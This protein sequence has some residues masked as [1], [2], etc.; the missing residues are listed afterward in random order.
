MYQLEKPR[1][2]ATLK[3]ETFS[4]KITTT[5]VQN[6]A[7]EINRIHTPSTMSIEWGDSSASDDEL[8]LEA[9]VANQ[10]SIKRGTDG[11]INGILEV[12]FGA[13][14]NFDSLNSAEWF[15][16]ENGDIFGENS[17]L[18]DGKDSYNR[19]AVTALWNQQAYL[20]LSEDEASAASSSDGVEASPTHSPLH[21]RLFEHTPLNFSDSGSSNDTEVRQPD[22]SSFHSNGFAHTPL[23]FSDSSS[24]MAS[25]KEV[26]VRR[27][28]VS[29]AWSKS[30]RFAA[31]VATPV[32]IALMDTFDIMPIPATSNDTIIEEPMDHSQNLDEID[33]SLDYDSTMFG[34]TPEL[35]DELSTESDHELPTESFE[36][37]PIIQTQQ[38]SADNTDQFGMGDVIDLDAKIGDSRNEIEAG[39]EEADSEEAKIKRG[40]LYA[41]GGMGFMAFMMWGLGKLQGAFHRGQGD[42]PIAAGDLAQTAGD[43]TGH[44]SRDAATLV[45]TEPT[46]ATGTTFQAGMYNAAGN[47]AQ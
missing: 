25:S 9:I 2:Y 15:T 24:S 11:E 8:W 40:F 20:D 36:D 6:V 28:A 44:L 34:S 1:W 30:I 10:P 19:E 3:L 45:A 35:D 12:P 18:S 31:Q 41:A 29:R 27:P 38:P 33:G 14:I 39:E 21:L 17:D 46:A 16:D 32:G 23:S 26:Q 7:F 4:N 43:T 47:T 5:T 13:S 22:V 42:D 37:E